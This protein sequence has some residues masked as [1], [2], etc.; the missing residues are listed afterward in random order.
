LVSS[1]NVFLRLCYAHRC[2]LF[3]IVN[4]FFGFRRSVHVWSDCRMIP[5][6]SCDF[7]HLSE[8]IS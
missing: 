7:R 8:P 4:R 2:T 6:F 5:N 1:G 3:Y